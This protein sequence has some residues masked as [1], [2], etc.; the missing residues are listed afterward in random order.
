MN[1]LPIAL[2]LMLLQNPLTSGTLQGV[3]VKAGT[4]ETVPNARVELRGV[5]EMARYGG[6]NYATTARDDGR[7]FFRNLRS[8]QYQLLASRA[9]Y[10]GVE[11]L[12]VTIETEKEVGQ[13]RVPMTLAGVIYGRVYDDKQR[14][15][16]NAEVDVMKVSSKGGRRTLEFN[17]SLTT[18]DLGEYRAFWLTPGR[19][20]V[21]A[22]HP[23]AG[24]FR[25]PTGGLGGY[26]LTIRQAVAIQL[27]ERRTTASYVPVFAPSTTD[28]HDAQA[29]DVG[30]GAEI[31]G[32][33]IS[34]FPV[35]KRAARGVIVDAQSAQPIPN[36]QL[37]V[38]RDPV[39][40]ND[41]PYI[42][43][44]SSNGA[45]EVSGLLPGSYTFLAVAG[46]LNRRI[47]VD[48]GEQ[49]INNLT[50]A[51]TAGMNVVGRVTSDGGSPAGVRVSLRREPEI[52]NFKITGPPDNGVVRE[53]GSFSLSAV[54]PGEYQ[55]AV[56]F[57]R[58]LQTAFVK[59]APDII[60]VTEEE[61]APLQI[62]IGSH[63][64][65]LDGRVFDAAHHPVP[66]V[67]A[68]L[69]PGYH[70]APTDASGRFHF[71]RLAPGN[72]RV[73]ASDVVDSV[74]LLEAGGT[75][76]RIVEGATT[77]ADTVLIPGDR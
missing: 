12:T 47:T 5:L 54:A 74:S 16:A 9:G 35:Q 26:R 25:S 6:V 1:V 7:F 77:N 39:R 45:F 21:S 50:I 73:F 36:A 52:P 72:Y 67:T 11:P 33:D 32:I 40:V 31:G 62:D 38:S 29:I 44:D 63:P 68:V 41:M 64:G 10:I 42:G 20:Y 19:Y 65:M 58:N 53:D 56:T 61:A 8:G 17:R 14:P 48:I 2:L 28:D 3:V 55:L 43:V 66:G 60:R 18:N 4:S 69:M 49:D 37:S 30:P 57:P 13:I 70:I 15:L 24:R 71:D 23:D 51:L 27:P 76:V 46:A 75:A 59:S 22:I 34:V